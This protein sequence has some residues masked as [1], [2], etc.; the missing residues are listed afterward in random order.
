MSNIAYTQNHRCKGSV[1]AGFR[2]LK[3][4]T[5]GVYA[6]C[7]HGWWLHMIDY[8]LDYSVHHCESVAQIWYCPFCA[9]KLG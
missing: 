4:A 9:T 5:L 7:K 2:I 1:D 3:D 6:G 8:D